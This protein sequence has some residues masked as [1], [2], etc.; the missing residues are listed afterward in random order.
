M[1]CGFVSN[2]PSGFFQKSYRSAPVQKQ[3]LDCFQV[4]TSFAFSDVV[5][6]PVAFPSYPPDFTEERFVLKATD[7]SVKMG[8]VLAFFRDDNK[9]KQKEK[10]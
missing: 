5:Q 3:R 6:R 7:L 8:Y 9:L 4:S 10:S 1:F 2:P